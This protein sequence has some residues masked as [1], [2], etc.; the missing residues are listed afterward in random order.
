MHLLPTDYLD[1]SLSLSFSPKLVR[2]AGVLHLPPSPFWFWACFAYSSRPKSMSLEMAVAPDFMRASY[3]A[4]TS[5]SI[6]P[7]LA[8]LILLISAFS[9]GSSFLISLENCKL[10]SPLLTSVLLASE[11]FNWFIG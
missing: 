2:A 11:N 6:S 9:L 5:S 4:W 1:C 8:M 7:L 3:L 10:S